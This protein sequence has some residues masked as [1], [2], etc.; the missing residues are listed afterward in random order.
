MKKLILILIISNLILFY[1]IFDNIRQKSFVGFLDIGQGNSVLIY[2]NKLQILYDAGPLGLKTVN[3]LNKYLSPYDKYIDIVIISHPDKDHYGGLFSILERYKIGLVIISPYV[4]QE[5]LYQKL[6][7]KIKDKNIS[8]ITLKEKDYIITNYEKL[9]FLNPP[10]KPFKNDNQN[11]IV[12][13]IFKNNK[14]FLLTG[15]IDHKIEKYLIKKFG[16]NILADYVLV[17]HH[18]SKYSS[19]YEFLRFLSNAFY[20][21]QVGSNNYGHPHKETL[22]RLEKLGIKYFRTDL[23]GDLLIY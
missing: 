14:N 16:K 9:Y 19:S 15:D 10:S 12:V 22:L 21:I 4:S 6:I 11:S 13:K 7:K 1:Y 3:K 5:S 20:V 2:N 18:G 23:G 17:P 8:L